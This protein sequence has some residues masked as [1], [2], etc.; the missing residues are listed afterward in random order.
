MLDKIV[1][2]SALLA[3]KKAMLATAESC[4]GGMIGAAMTGRPGSSSVYERGFITYSNDAKHEMLGVPYDLLDKYGAVSV[5]CARAMADGAIKASKADLAI[6]VTGIA[7][8]DGGSEEKPVGTVYI[9]LC[10]KGQVPEARHHSFEGTR[11]DIRRQSVV[12]ALEMAIYALE[13]DIV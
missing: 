2:L 1:K 10:I 7:G 6:S 3:K 8:P 12:A 5:E 4:T 11:E 13:E 9:G